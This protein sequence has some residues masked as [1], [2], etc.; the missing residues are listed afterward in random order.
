VVAL[1][2][3]QEITQ[4][5]QF[6]VGPMD[7]WSVHV[8]ELIGIFYAIDM[9]FRLAH[10]R[11]NDAYGRP[12]AATILCDSKSALQSIQNTR[13][14][15]GQRIVHAILSA[16]AEVQAEGTAL[17]LQWIPGHCEEPGND[18]ADRLAREAAR[19]GKSHTFRPLLTREVAHIRRGIQ[20]QW[21]REWKSKSTK[22]GQLR[23]ID[24]GLPATYTGD[25]TE[26][27]P[28]GGR[29]C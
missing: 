12:I 17:R 23:K 8:A 14:K 5:E 22:G 24:N 15:S 28:G 20:A 16:A 27:C 26:A 29:T 25:Y 6:Q 2:K 3:N 18:A 19:P 9:V 1:D 7:R 11:S 21:E 10:Q 13:N 4:Y